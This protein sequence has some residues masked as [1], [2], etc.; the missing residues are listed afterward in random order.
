MF[1]DSH[2]P[3][4]VQDME[5]AGFQLRY[6]DV[7]DR[8]GELLRLNHGHNSPYRDCSPGHNWLAGFLKRHPGRFKLIF[9][10]CSVRV[11]TDR[12]RKTLDTERLF[13]YVPLVTLLV[14]HAYG[15]MTLAISV[16][17]NPPK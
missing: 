5:T 15:P 12:L 2:I 16:K 17:S 14:R 11:F 7:R 13:N 4:C 6:I 8:A 1:R 9:L 10:L 3:L